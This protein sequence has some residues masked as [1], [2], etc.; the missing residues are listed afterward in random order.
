MS[1]NPKWDRNKPVVPFDRNGNMLGEAYYW[2][3]TVDWVSVGPWKTTME[4]VDWHNTT[5]SATFTLKDN[6]GKTYPIYL[7]DFYDVVTTK[8][9]VNGLIEESVWTFKKIGP[10]YAILLHKAV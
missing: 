8:H 2:Q 9:I 10:K 1:S 6:K 7:S 3:A 5:G 4:I